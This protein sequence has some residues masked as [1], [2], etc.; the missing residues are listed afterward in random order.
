MNEK[1]GAGLPPVSL[2]EAGPAPVEWSRIAEHES[3]RKEVH[4]P[5]T[6]VH[7]WWARRLGSVARHLLLAAVSGPDDSVADAEARLRGLVVYDPFAGSGTTLVEAAK[8][9]AAVVGRDINPVATL[10]QRQALQPWDLEVL[11][12]LFGQV[13]RKCARPVQELHRTASNE[14]VLHYFWVALAYCP[15]CGEDVELFTT[16]VFARH[17]YPR[18]HPRAQAV[19]PGCRGVCVTDLSKDERGHCPACGMAFSFQ[20]AARGRFMTCRHGHRTPV[21]A[22]LNGAVPE[23]RMYA[24]LVLRAD[25]QREYRA[26][27]DFDL[28]LYDKAAKSLA[29]TSPDELVRPLGALEEGV[30]TIQALRWGYDSWER[31]FNERQRYSLGLIGAALRDLPGA[32]AEREALIASFGRT[33]EHHNLFCS[34][35]GEGTGPVRSVFHNHVLRPERCSVEGDPWGAQGGSA[36]FSGVLTRLH[37]AAQYKSTPLDFRAEAGRVLAVDQS[38]LPV[39]RPLS[40][41]W[42]QFVRNPAT[43]YT[44]TGDASQTDLPDNSVDLIVTDPPYVDNVHYSEL[45]DFFHAWLSAMRPYQGYPD[46]PS[47]RAVQE[48]QNASPDGFQATAARVWRECRRVLKPGGCLLFSFHQSQT[49]GWCALMRSL[50]DAGFTVTTTRA[51]IAEVATSLSKTAA[52]EPNRIDVIVLCRDAASTSA[53]AAP[54]LDQAAAQAL[55]EIQGLR[56]A[57]LRV[58]PGDVRTAVRAAVLATGTR[59]VA[60]DWETLQAEADQRATAAVAEFNTT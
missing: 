44:T 2:L 10:T 26:I 9:G 42:Q 46:M 39:A 29:D 47:T 28:C 41:T 25:G 15:E 49:T 8:L 40:T 36:G 50:S 4:R 51:V 1:P 3:W 58:G 24:K 23:R 34:Y 16:R 7:K 22:A 54:D 45:A 14:P 38:S 20:G 5:A 35:K 31:F 60:A 37:K 21:I 32:S 57:G 53:G 33:V 27:D 18:R 43:A 12:D 48:V 55:S 56:G 11:A 59:Q 30:S 52:A 13:V 19:C 17:A 6:Y